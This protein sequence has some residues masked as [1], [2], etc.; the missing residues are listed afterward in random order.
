MSAIEYVCFMVALLKLSQHSAISLLRT[1]FRKINEGDDEEH[2][3]S[4][5]LNILLFK[6]LIKYMKIKAKQ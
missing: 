5:K 1:T 6:L 3:L 4:R 2:D